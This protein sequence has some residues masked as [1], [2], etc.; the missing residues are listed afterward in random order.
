MFAA[1]SFSI[2]SACTGS[3]LMD[4]YPLFQ[5]IRSP[6]VRC[7]SVPIRHSLKASAGVVVLRVEVFCK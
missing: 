2:K 5:I 7:G 1:V 4:T 6:L 3:L